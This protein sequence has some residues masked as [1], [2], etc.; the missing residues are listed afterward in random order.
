MK[1]SK[2]PPDT[3]LSTSPPQPGALAPLTRK[4]RR[5]L[6]RLFPSMALLLSVSGCQLV[7][8]ARFSYANAKA[9]HQWANDQLTTTVP[10]TLV[11]NHII[12]PVQVN[13]SG[14]LN[15]V[16]DSGAGATVIIDSRDSRALQLEMQGELP[17]S[18]TGTGPDTTAH[19]VPDTTLSLG[20]VSLQ[21]L[22]V[23][24]LPLASIPFFDDFDHVYF[25]GVI[26][27]P[28][29]ARFTVEIDYDRR[30]VTFTEPSAV[31]ER[32]GNPGDSWREVPLK[33]E[34]GVPY[35]T[36]QVTPGPGKSVEVKLLVDT[37]FRG[38]VS[39]TPATDE[40][41]DEPLEYFQSVDQGLSGDVV[42]RV[43]M[44]DSLTLSGY[45]LHGLPIHYAMAGG[46]SE[47]DSNGILGNSVLQQFNLVFDYANTRLFLRPN[48][49]FETPINA[50]RSGLQIRPHVAGGIVKLI[51]P[52]SAGQASALQV[53]DII[54]SFD[55]KPVNY[56]SIA[57]LKRALGAGRDSVR[58][59]W[60]S[61]EAQRCEDLALASRFSKNQS[62]APD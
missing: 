12:L 54:T 46:E 28:F 26:G 57:D 61:G 5:S 30:L 27:A 51:A 43:A 13:G 2:S 17:V 45:Q 16:L 3:F 50:D 38:A 47:G 6:A 20:G 58:L 37:G 11:D 56:Q 52:G 48:R 59:C 7:D 31:A 36:A 10:F 24:Y 39:L 1:G 14:P 49:N 9:T 25:D 32:L 18:G 23:I 19:I 42:S 34:S 35:M 29:F 33:I 53:G 60:L 40:D 44:A 55:D 15:F 22:S 4:L 41:L 8:M 62:L 21:G